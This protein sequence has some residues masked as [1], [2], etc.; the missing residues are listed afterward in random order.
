MDYFHV[1]M[2]GGNLYND[3][4]E[5]ELTSHDAGYT[6]NEEGS[7]SA[8]M[9][10]IK[11]K[12]LLSGVGI[13]FNGKVRITS[14]GGI[15]WT[16][17][18]T[19]ATAH[20]RHFNSL[21]YADNLNLFAVGGDIYVDSLQSIM[22]SSDG[23]SNWTLIRDTAGYWLNS[24]Y[25]VSATTGIAVGD[26]GTILISSNSGAS[27]SKKTAPGSAA[28]RNF[29]SVYFV[30][31]STGFIVGGNHTNDS[32]QTILKTTDGGNSWN[33]IR[34]TISP[35]LNSV[36]FYS[37]TSGYA[38]GDRGV[39]LKTINGGTNWTPVILPSNPNYDFFAVHFLNENY[40]YLTGRWGISYRYDATTANGPGA[41][42]LDATMVNLTSANLRGSVNPNHINTSIK[43]EYGTSA[44]YGSVVSAYPGNSND[45][46]YIDVNY[47]LTGLT[48]HSTYHY[49]VVALNPLDTAYGLDKTFYTG[50]IPNVNTY[51]ASNV[52]LN[53]AQLNGMVIANNSPAINKFEY[54]TSTSYGTEVIAVPDSSFGNYDVNISINLTGLTPGI[55]Y[56]YRVKAT[57]IDGTGYGADMTF[58]TS[59]IPSVATFPAT[60]QTTNSVR[61]N[62]SV[63]P[64]NHPTANKF[65]W[66]TSTSYGNTVDAI[67]DSVTGTASV[68]ILYDLS[69]LTYNTTYHYRV[70]ATNSAGTGY[71]SDMTF[72]TG[73]PPIL[74]T[75]PAT[76]ISQNSARLNGTID[77]GGIP[78]A[79]SFEYGTSTAYGS[80]ITADPDSSLANGFINVSALLSGLMP[81][82]TYHFRIKGTNNI[83]TNSGEDIQFYSG[84]PEIPNFNFELW[85]TISAT[86]PD[87]WDLKLGSFSQITQSCHGDYAIRLSNDTVS[88]NP[89]VI[90]IGNSEDGQV[91]YGG[92]PFA[93]RPDSLIGCFNYSIPA[94]DTAL[95]M[96]FLKKQGVFISNNTFKIYG[97]SSGS[98][99]QLKFPLHYS[100]T[101]MPDS[102]IFG[103]VCTDIRFG[104]S[105]LNP[106]NVLDVDYLRF[107]GTSELIPNY[108]FENWTTLY[109][110]QLESWYNSY[111]NQYEL[112]NSPFK[113]ITQTTDAQS[114]EYA[115]ILK[116]KI[117]L[118]DTISGNI[119]TNPNYFG[120]SFK[121]TVRHHSLT[122]FYKFLPENNDSLNILV[123]M[124]KNGSS[125]GWG[126]F[127]AGNTVSDYTSFNINI[128]YMNDTITP[129]SGFISISAYKGMKAKGNSIL[130]VDNLNFDGYLAGIE[131][132][133]VS[134]P[135]AEIDFTVYPN[136]FNTLTNIAF[137]INEESS[138]LIRIFD[139]SGKQ[140]ALIADSKFFPGNYTFDFDAAGLRKGLYIC[141]IHT[142][143]KVI[144]KKIILN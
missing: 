34:D 129:D 141:V 61:L 26:R 57:N 87:T 138:V 117:S 96:L 78:T 109:Y 125:V 81:N 128:F 105:Q 84:N 132:P 143:K 9:R 106:N 127:S 133:L 19:P 35:C 50:N 111:S 21:C 97:S 121:V 80:V 71:G 144:S 40:G 120:P 142:D 29:Y 85:D 94:N 8:W 63:N 13:G 70:K 32:I 42:T 124:Y 18:I 54:G 59:E 115:V 5:T 116:S 95:I 49:R 7:M 92:T 62:G 66:G 37:Q 135:E 83:T 14:D 39:V 60:N 46:N 68:N 48:P 74:Y 6:W 1:S 137:S 45:S 101:E 107:T 28:T 4:I 76:E 33:I 88:N 10:D 44:S 20:Q 86:V 98:Y 12:S 64:N 90:L 36:H 126:N 23:G 41:I 103:I 123:S 99:N 22:H 55:T 15:S 16:A 140:L 77:A 89:G 122:G 38:A 100:S 118:N 75:F 108:D 119:T 110:P 43:F 93:S 79:V 2:V 47:N 56:H 25:F 27:W 11:Y 31:S 52:T 104:I 17:G 130:Y 136:P 139:I 67:P 91:F 73:S 112:L 65:E 53:S 3:S 72:T 82:T 131:K 102:M 24:V 69:G 134:N 51:P 58:F 114:G 30:N 113:P